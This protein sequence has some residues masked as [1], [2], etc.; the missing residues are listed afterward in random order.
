MNWTYFPDGSLKTRTDAPSAGAERKSFAYAYD[1]NGNK[2]QDVSKKMNADNHSAY[3]DSTTDYTY[4]P[5]NRLTKVTKTGN[6]AGT[7]TYLKG[8]STSFT[9]DRPCRR[10]HQGT[11]R[12]NVEDHHVRL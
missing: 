1:A 10:A 4:D 9:Y 6:G 8:T 7:E 2:S 11:A 12:R 3:L 5:V